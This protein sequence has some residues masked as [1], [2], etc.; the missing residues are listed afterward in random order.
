MPISCKNECI[1]VTAIV[2]GDMWPTQPITDIKTVTSGFPTNERR[3]YVS[4]CWRGVLTP[5]Y[6]EITQNKCYTHITA[7]CGEN[8][9][10]KQ[11]S[12]KHARKNQYK[13]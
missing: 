9:A 13:L 3:A 6:N 2:N 11:A 4:A 12:W 5:E 8:A 10:S 7:L 1:K